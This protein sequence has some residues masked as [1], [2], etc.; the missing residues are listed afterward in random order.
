MRQKKTPERLINEI[1]CVTPKKEKKLKALSNTIYDVEIKEVA[2][3]GKRVKIHSKAF[4]EKYDKW[5][6]FDE[7]NLPV[8]RVERV[9][10][11][12]DVSLEERI[13]CFH[14]R[15][16]REIKRKLFSGRESYFLLLMKMFSM[17]ELEVLLLRQ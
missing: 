2:E 16:K 3:I 11:P 9:L 15:L 1:A 14:E 6:P 13:Q 7:N 5:R 4:T 8:I 10:Q 17:K 12:T